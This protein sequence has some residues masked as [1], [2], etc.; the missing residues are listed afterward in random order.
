MARVVFVDRAKHVGLAFAWILLFVAVGVSATWVLGKVFVASE[1][2]RWKL[3]GDSAAAALGFLFSTAVV[4][5]LLDRHSWDRMGWHSAS[6]W[7]A[8]AGLALRVGRGMGLGVAMAA[9]AIGLAFLLSHASFQVQGDW[10]RYGRAVG[11]L[12]I[13]LLLAALFEELLFR[14]YA[15]RRLAEGIGPWAATAVS[16]VAFSW[17]H[18]PN[19]AVTVLAKLNIFLAGIWLAFAFFS[20]GGM[21]LAWGLHFGWNAGLALVFDAPVSGISFY[22]PAVQYA[23]GMHAW[24]DGGGFGPEGGAAGTLVFLAGTA[25]I[26]GARLKQPKAWLA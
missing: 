23:P 12:L 20:A 15:I 21:S 22:V 16:A 11:P 5:R 10:G 18:F 3:A 7:G 14:G 26:L 6:R 2:S 24:V 4:G 25:L 9:A 8:G 17:A 13:G 19:P 1:T